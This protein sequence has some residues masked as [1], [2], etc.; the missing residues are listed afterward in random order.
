MNLTPYNKITI[1]YMSYLD[2]LKHLRQAAPDDPWLEGETGK[3]WHERMRELR[4][5]PNG[6]KLHSLC[7]ESIGWKESPSLKLEPTESFE[8]A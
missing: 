2:L 6:E 7:C 5:L 8:S 4:A 3:Y 1:D